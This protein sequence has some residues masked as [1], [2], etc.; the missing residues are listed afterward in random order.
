VSAGL[1]KCS[2]G[3]TNLAGLDNCHNCG[4][5]RAVLIRQEQELEHKEGEAIKDIIVTT[6][7]I[8]EPYTIIDT[9][10]TVD[11]NKEESWFF[12]W[13]ENPMKAFGRV[14]MNLR[15]LCYKLGGDAII[16]CQFEY[17]IA[18]TGDKTQ[19]L[20]IFAYGTV[21]KFMNKEQI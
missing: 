7:D 20:E 3:T 14:K 16:H 10:F 11:N 15:R 1:W 4:L 13:A 18:L 8:K 9:I 21:V 5:E 19:I 12:T 6:G 2:C 17:R